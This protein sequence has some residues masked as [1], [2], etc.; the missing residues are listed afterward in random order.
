MGLSKR[1]CCQ[2]LFLHLCGCSRIPFFLLGFNCCSSFLQNPDPWNSE[3][4]RGTTQAI[5]REPFLTKWELQLWAE[6]TAPIKFHFGHSRWLLQHLQPW[7]LHSR[8]PSSLQTSPR[9]SRRGFWGIIKSIWSSLTFNIPPIPGISRNNSKPPQGAPGAAFEGSQRTFGAVWPP[10]FHLLLG[11]AGAIPNH[12]KGLQE[13]LLRN[14]T[15][16]FGAVWLEQFQARPSWLLAPS[17]MFI[18]FTDPPWQSLCLPRWLSVVEFGIDFIKMRYSHFCFQPSFKWK[19][20]LKTPC[21][22]QQQ[23]DEEKAVLLCWGWHSFY[24]ITAD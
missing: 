1:C 5:P 4:T 6:L 24:S 9:S 15:E 13:M 16:Y 11:W 23:L 22:C 14:H 20:E 2:T 21:L 10:A 12:P 8:Q 7:I 18:P 3:R 19:A 17:E